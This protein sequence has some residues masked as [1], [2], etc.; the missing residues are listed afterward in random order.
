MTFLRFGEGGGREQSLTLPKLDAQH[1]LVSLVRVWGWEEG[2]GERR[3]EEVSFFSR[4]GWSGEEGGG[5]R[6]FF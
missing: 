3:V 1:E 5:G 4:R 6:S 2:W